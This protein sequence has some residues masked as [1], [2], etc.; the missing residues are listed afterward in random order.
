MPHAFLPEGY[1]LEDDDNKIIPVTICQ[2]TDEDP[3]F[4]VDVRVLPIKEYRAV[5]AKL[6]KSQDGG[7]RQAK[8]AQ[9][10]VDRDYLNKV[11]RGWNGLTPGNWNYLVRDGKKLVVDSSLTGNVK[12]EIAFSAEAVFYLYRNTWPQDFGNK[13]FEAVQAGAAEQ[14]EE[15]ESLKK[16]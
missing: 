4:V 15:E 14:E 2:G 6:Q 5:F 10:K 12:K 13:V 9:D 3:P 1:A 16:G 11:V 8:D 7:F